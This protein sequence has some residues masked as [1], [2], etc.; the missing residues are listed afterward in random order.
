MS[1]E[2]DVTSSVPYSRPGEAIRW[3]TEILGLHVARTWGPEGNPV[4]AY[5]TWQTG[6]IEIS[7]RPSGGDM[8]WSLLGPVSIGL[9]ADEE[10]IRAAYDRAVAAQAEIVRVL[11]FQKNPAVPDGYL[12]FTLRDPEGNLWSMWSRGPRF[13]LPL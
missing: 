7:L 4:F 12:G 11:D 10:T 2:P 13:E 9:L 3:L 1:F 8:P 5:L 6:V